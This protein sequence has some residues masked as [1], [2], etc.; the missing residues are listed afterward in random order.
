M[1]HRIG[2][3]EPGS[4]AARAGLRAGDRLIS[5]DGQNVIDFVDYQA[6]CCARRLRLAVERDESGSISRSK[7]TSTRRWGWPLTTS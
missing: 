3:G 7:R 6:L 2:Q 4:P 5:I 1:N